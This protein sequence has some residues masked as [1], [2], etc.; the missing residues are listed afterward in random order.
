MSKIE[1]EHAVRY[2]TEC[3]KLYLF[4]D[5]SQRY[6]H[7]FAHATIRTRPA[8]SG[9][10]YFVP[11]AL[12]GSCIV[13]EETFFQEPACRQLAC[14]PVKNDQ[15]ESCGGSSEPS[16]VPLGT[17]HVLA[18]QPA[19]F[20]P[21]FR[22]KMDTA[23]I[24][25][26]CVEVN[27]YK[28]MF[29][30]NPELLMDLR[31]RKNHG[32]LVWKDGRLYLTREY[33]LAY[34]LDFDGQDC[35]ETQGQTVGEF[36]FGKTL[37]RT[38]R[39]EIETVTPLQ[40]DPPPTVDASSYFD[41]YPPIE[42]IDPIIVST[43]RLADDDTSVLAS[44]IIKDLSIDFGLDLSEDVVKHLLKKKIPKL[45]H[46]ALKDVVVKSAVKQMVIR[47]TSQIAI[48]LST[49]AA[50]S[51]GGISHILLVV[52]IVSMVLDVIDPKDYDKVLDAA[53]LER[54]DRKLDATY[55]GHAIN[56]LRVVTPEYV[57]DYVLNEEDESERYEYMAE[58]I[59]EYLAALRLQ[60]QVDIPK[61]L[62][63]VVVRKRRTKRVRP[64]SLYAVV[65]TL[66]MLMLIF[67]RWIP[68]LALSLLLITVGQPTV[69]KYMKSIG[70]F[71]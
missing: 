46:K 71:K 44:S 10:D 69:T 9:R 60:P 35:F 59:R 30:M 58:K 66:L 47:S 11:D 5:Y 40:R 54:I 26:K 67:E 62:P 23:W 36:F 41:A 15:L 68:I 43:V 52:G 63:P 33:C 61:N 64:W 49:M 51:L 65:G 6:P 1:L 18:C 53:R 57:W 45:V 56:Q 7:L 8:D 55:F 38:I 27:P 17:Q 31:T 2:A 32:G 28:K 34:G 13:V 19:C 50:R 4:N 37:Y 42:D 39:N 14:F 70:P 3:T 12:A 48:R 16:W 29:A 25:N 21:R 20:D 24:A 22:Y